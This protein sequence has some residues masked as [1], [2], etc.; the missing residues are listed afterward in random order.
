MSECA[1]STRAYSRL[2]S[3][4]V[5]K[6]LVLRYTVHLVKERRCDERW[7]THGWADAGEATVDTH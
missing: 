4:P 5:M 3:T 2:F 1:L 6:G 7:W